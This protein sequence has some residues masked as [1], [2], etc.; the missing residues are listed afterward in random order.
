M[1]VLEERN[2]S[3][4]SSLRRNSSKQ[5]FYTQPEVEVEDVAQSKEVVVV[6]VVEIRIKASSSKS[7][8]HMIRRD[9]TQVD[10][11]T[12]EAGGVREVTKI[13]K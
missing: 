8:K 4:D 6:V 7:N 3:E 5:A 11:E 2:N 13:S 10:K 12:I 9:Q 1:L